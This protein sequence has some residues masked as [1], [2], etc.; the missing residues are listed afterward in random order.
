MYCREQTGCTQNQHESRLWQIRPAN[1]AAKGKESPSYPG[2]RRRRLR[3][4]LGRR[5]GE[6]ILLLPSHLIK[7]G[8][9][10]A[11][12]VSSKD[13]KIEVCLEKTGKSEPCSVQDMFLLALDES[14]ADLGMMGRGEV[15]PNNVLPMTKGHDGVD[16]RC[17]KVNKGF[18][19]TFSCGK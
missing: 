10:A 9:A 19:I 15:D 8:A 7:S 1:S 18:P 16:R 14:E 5:G 13:T 2:V 17:L 4:R 6:I 11:E 3:R 12:T